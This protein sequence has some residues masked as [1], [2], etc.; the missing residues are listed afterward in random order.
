MSALCSHELKLNE[1]ERTKLLLVVARYSN[2]QKKMAQK[3]AMLQKS[4]EVATA[5]PVRD[6][7]AA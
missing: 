7:A 5:R 4:I 3:W 2:E 6:A 1:D